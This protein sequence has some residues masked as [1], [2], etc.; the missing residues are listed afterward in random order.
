MDA[1]A[2]ERR[3]RAALWGLAA[4]ILVVAPVELLLTEHTE[5]GPQL[6]PYVLSVLGL[7]SAAAGAFRPS[8]TSLRISRV[9]SGI[10]IA[11]AGFGCW[12]HLEHNYAFAVEIAPSGTFSEH[13]IEAILGANP[14][15]AP[16]IYGLAGLCALAAA[17]AHPEG[18][19]P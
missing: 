6:I 9:V 13:A 8:P 7:G 19:T 16:G 5:P 15:L 10:L 11:G 18:A 14:L 4:A 17:W 3:L 1:A 12:E 2:R